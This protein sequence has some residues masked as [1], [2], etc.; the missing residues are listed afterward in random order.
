MMQIL[1]T[2]CRCADQSMVHRALTCGLISVRSSA[3]PRPGAHE[4]GDSRIT[5]LPA[6]RTT[7][8]VHPPTSGRRRA[9]TSL[10]T[11]SSISLLPT[12][13]GALA[14]KKALTVVRAAESAAQTSSLFVCINFGK[15]GG[16]RGGSRESDPSRE[17]P[18]RCQ[19]ER[20]C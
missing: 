15:G 9:A 7:A 2:Q 8:P 6:S 1:L 16:A 11:V 20:F 18:H 3:S 5:E 17:L 19:R 12:G 13:N 10:R 14:T 4:F